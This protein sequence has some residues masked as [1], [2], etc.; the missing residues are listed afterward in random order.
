MT[1]D[2]VWD[3]NFIFQK[4]NKKRRL[5][6][7]LISIGYNFHPSEFGLGLTF[8]GNCD[9]YGVSTELSGLRLWDRRLLAWF[10]AT[11]A[12]LG[13]LANLNDHLEIGLV[14]SWPIRFRLPSHWGLIPN[15]CKED[16]LFSKCGG[17]SDT[18]M[19][20]T[21]KLVPGDPV[22]ASKPASYVGLLT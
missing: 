3:G 9:S 16:S 4:Q 21:W 1:L 20:S 22:L 18:W 11:F 17:C 10:T 12:E 15:V 6:F 19:E 7:L 14:L 2:T 13:S 8:L 5:F